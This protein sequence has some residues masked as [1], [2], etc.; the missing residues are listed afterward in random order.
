MRWLWRI[1]VVAALLVPCVYAAEEVVLPEGKSADYYRILLRK[2]RPGYLFDRFLNS[3]VES[4]DLQ[5][6]ETFLEASDD[7][8]AGAL[9]AFYYEAVGEPARASALYE[10]LIDAQP[11]WLELLYYK[12]SVDSASGAYELAAEELELLL[13]GKPDADLERDALK[14][15]GR[16]LL[17]SGREQE[18]LAAW[19]RLLTASGMEPDV[20]E[21]LLDMQLAEGLYDEALAN[22]DRLLK[23]TKDPYREVMLRLRR[24]SIL[25]RVDRRDD[26]IAGLREA[27]ALTGE[28]SW[29]RRDVMSR[30]EL[31]Y[32]GEDNLPGL[33]ECLDEMLEE[34]PGNPTLLKASAE[35]ARVR[36]RED[37]A[38]ESARALVRL[39]P[40]ARETKDWYVEMLLDMARYEEA[41]ATLEGFV[42][43]Y[44]EDNTLRARLAN[45]SHQAGD[46]EQ[47]LAWSLAYLQASAKAESDYMD[48]ARS[49][50]RFGLNDEATSVY[51]D[52]LAQWPDSPEGREAV[53]THLSRESYLHLEL[54]W[55]HYEWLAK[56]CDAETLTRLSAILLAANNPRRACQLLDLRAD[57]FSGDYR[58]LT[59]LFEATSA[60]QEPEGLLEIGQARIAAAESI[61]ELELATAALVYE[62]KKNGQLAE[63][64]E[65]LSAN[66]ERSENEFWLLVALRVA[67]NDSA[68]ADQLIL[69]ALENDPGNEMLL[70]C[71]LTLAKQSR[72]WEKAEQVL[73]QLIEGNPTQ[74]ALW[75]REL[76]PVLTRDGRTDEALEWI[77]DWKKVSPNA[78]RPYE[79]ERDA[80]LAANRYNEAIDAMRTATR[81]FDE[82]IDLKLALGR[83]YETRGRTADAEQLYW[84]LLN[85]EE[86]LEG[87]M[88]RLTDLIRLNQQTGLNKLIMELEIRSENA[89]ASPFPLLALAECYRVNHRVNERAEI[90]D[91]VLELRPND[92][93]VLRAK[94]ALE[95]DLGDYVAARKLMLRIA[96]LD[97]NGGAYAK[98][99]EF[100][101]LYGEPAVAQTMVEDPRISENVEEMVS[102]AA[103]LISAG[104]FELIEKPLAELAEKNPED[105]RLAFLVGCLLQEQGRPVVA[106]QAFA[107]LLKVEQE[108]PGAGAGASWSAFNAPNPMLGNPSMEAQKQRVMAQWK[109]QFGAWV[110]D[111][112][113]EMYSLAM[114]GMGSGR[115]R[116]NGYNTPTVSVDV[117]DSLEELE[118]ATL[119][120]LGELAPDV[121]EE[122]R[123]ALTAALDEHQPYLGL[124]AIRSARGVHSAEWWD[125]AETCYPEDEQIRLLRT[126]VASHTIESEEEIRTTIAQ[127]AGD[128]PELSF[129]LLMRFQHR[130][131]DLLP[132]VV[133]SVGHID[134]TEENLEV[135]TRVSAMALAGIA[136]TNSAYPAVVDLFEKVEAEYLAS[137][138]LNPEIRLQ[139]AA[140]RAKMENDYSGIL[141]L[142]EEVFNT[143]Q[144]L[145][146]QAA[147]YYPGMS[148]QQALQQIRRHQLQFTF[149]PNWLPNSSVMATYMMQQFPEES[150]EIL[151]T[152]RARPTDSLFRWLA[153][154]RMEKDAGILNAAAEAV[155]AKEPKTED[156]LFALACWYSVS[157][158][159]EQAMD[160]VLQLRA[161][162]T[163]DAD[164]REAWDAVILTL[165]ARLDSIPAD[166]RERYAEIQ[167]NL[168]KSKL[169]NDRNER[170]KLIGFL[171]LLGVPL[172]E[173]AKNM[174][175]SS[176]ASSAA[177]RHSS[178][179][180][181]QRRAPDF[182]QQIRTAIDQQQ[183]VDTA[184][185]RVAIMARSEALRAIHPQRSGY[186]Q[187]QHVLKNCLQ[188]I[189][190]HGLEERFLEMF[191]SADHEPTPREMFEYAFTLDLVGRSE[192]ALELYAQVAEARPDWEGVRTRYCVGLAETDPARALEIM[193]G[194][195]GSQR[196]AFIN[197]FQ[198]R[199]YDN[200][201]SFEDRLAMTELVFGMIAADETLDEQMLQQYINIL[202]NS[203]RNNWYF[204]Q[205]GQNSIALPAL[206]HASE[207]GSLGESW[208]LSPGQLPNNMN[209]GKDAARTAVQQRRRELNLEILKL[210]AE[211]L[212]GMGGNHYSQWTAYVDFTDA[213][214]DEDAAFL[215]ARRL[216]GAAPSNQ[217]YSY[218]NSGVPGE[219]REPLEVYVDEL[220]RRGDWSDADVLLEEMNDGISKTTLSALMEI[221]QEDDAV[222]Y[223]EHLKELLNGT[224]RGRNQGSV[225]KLLLRYHVE[226]GRSDDLEPLVWEAISKR[227]EQNDWS[228]AGGLAAAWVTSGEN[229]DAGA[230]FSRFIDELFTPAEQE[231]LASAAI[232]SID[233]QNQQTIY[234]KYQHISGVFQSLTLPTE[235]LSAFFKAVDPIERKMRHG[236]I[237]NNMINQMANQGTNVEW[238]QHMGFLGTWEEFPFFAFSRGNQS[239]MSRLCDQLNGDAG[240]PL[241]EAIDQ[242][243]EPTFG[244]E[245]MKAVV[246]NNSWSKRL[247]NMLA[248]L[249]DDLETVAENPEL[250]DWM[251]EWFF[252]MEA[253][254]NTPINASTLSAD[255]G[256]VLEAYAA[257]RQVFILEAADELLAF[258]LS[259]YLRNTNH[260]LQQLRQIMGPLV[261][262]DPKR[263]RALIDRSRRMLRLSYAVQGNTG[264]NDRQLL[265]QVFQRP[266]Y[267]AEEAL[268]VI[269]AVEEMASVPAYEWLTESYVRQMGHQLERRYRDE[270]MD[271]RE[272][273]MAAA[274]EALAVLLPLGDEISPESSLELAMRVDRQDRSALGE[275]V[276]EQAFPVSN[277]SRLINIYLDPE[278]AD[279]EW[280]AAYF[281]D[282]DQP[283]RNRVRIYSILNG[284]GNNKPEVL[285]APELLFGLVDALE[286][287]GSIRLP[288]DSYRLLIDRVAALEDEN[289]KT[290]WIGRLLSLWRAERVDGAPSNRDTIYRLVELTSA[291]GLDDDARLLLG[292]QAIGRYP[293]TYAIALRHGYYDFVE[294]ALPGKLSNANSQF[295]MNN[296]WIPESAVSWREQ[297]AAGVEDGRQ[298]TFLSVYLAAFPVR[299]DEGTTLDS[300]HWKKCYGEAVAAVE[301]REMARWLLRMRNHGNVK[302]DA[303]ELFLKYVEI[304]DFQTVL[305]GG[306]IDIDAYI[307]Y[308]DLLAE[309]EDWERLESMLDEL[310]ASA[311]R[312]HYNGSRRQNGARHLI[313]CC[314]NAGDE[315]LEKKAWDTA[316]TLEQLRDSNA[317]MAKTRRSMGYLSFDASD[318]EWE[319]LDPAARMAAY[320]KFD[321]DISGQLMQKELTKRW[322]KYIAEGF[323]QPEAR[324]RARID[325]F[326]EITEKA[327]PTEFLP[328]HQTF[329]QWFSIHFS[330]PDETA[331]LLQYLHGI[332][333]D[334]LMLAQ[335]K[336]SI[337]LNYLE[338]YSQLVPDRRTADIEAYLARAD[339]DDVEKIRF[340]QYG[341]AEGSVEPVLNQM[342][343]HL[344]ALLALTNNPELINEQLENYLLVFPVPVSEEEFACYEILLKSLQQNDDTAAAAKSIRILCAMG[345][346]DE[347]EA[348]MDQHS[349]KELNSEIFAA[350]LESGAVDWCEQQLATL[351]A[352]P[353]AER[354]AAYAK[355]DENMATQWAKRKKHDTWYYKYLTYDLDYAAER[356]LAVN[357]DLWFNPAFKGFVPVHRV[358]QNYRWTPELEQFFDEKDQNNRMVAHAMA[359]ISARRPFQDTCRSREQRT[360]DIER[361]LTRD[362]LDDIEILDFAVALKSVSIAEVM[363]PAS[364]R[365]V[366][367]ALGRNPELMESMEEAI[368]RIA[369]A[370]AGSADATIYNPCV[371]RLMSTY[372][373]MTPRERSQSV[374]K[375]SELMPT[376]AALERTDDFD[377][378]LNDDVLNAGTHAGMFRHALNQGKL[379]WCLQWLEP[380]LT[381]QVRSEWMADHGFAVDEDQLNALLA[382]VEDPD[383]RLA[384]GI[385]FEWLKAEEGRAVDF[386]PFATQFNEQTFT[387]VLW[388][389][390]SRDWLEKAGVINDTGPDPLLEKWAAGII[391]K[392]KGGWQGFS[393]PE[394]VAFEVY[395][396]SLLNAG[397]LDEIMDFYEAL[398]EMGLSSERATWLLDI[399]SRDDKEMVEAMLSG[400]HVV[401]PSRYA[402]LTPVEHYKFQ[403]LLEEVSKEI[404]VTRVRETISHVAP[405]VFGVSGNADDFKGKWN[406]ATARFDLLFG[407]FLLYS[408]EVGAEP[409]EARLQELIG[410]FCDAVL[411]YKDQAPGGYFGRY[412]WNEAAAFIPGTYPYSLDTGKWKPIVSEMIPS[413]MTKFSEP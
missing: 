243:E 238:M 288:S 341:L 398:P 319:K 13:A 333:D 253:Y 101:A 130:Y 248:T 92:V 76:V 332:E 323:S 312:E 140:A 170:I 298:K 114:Y 279:S 363:S 167:N 36:G 127:L 271:S 109:M 38:I 21:E 388:M 94:A 218:S 191:V 231:I 229:V 241:Q 394:E 121:P 88:T 381:E 80:L 159:V 278:N 386:E 235:S 148:T 124:L 158:K 340:I 281:M 175:F 83:L 65:K 233:H 61:E 146:E 411:I 222:L 403:S 348:I 35:L 181:S 373:A 361:Y 58:Y 215:I 23:A 28:G 90:L 232:A 322:D 383:L 313:K 325:L 350:A 393:K 66:T 306:D 404:P 79:L 264:Y 16:S 86:T 45:V 296:V 305:L 249:N 207:K 95:E 161:S 118:T 183:D 53:A 9:L 280:L 389:A 289:Q 354:A 334:S 82:S 225:L 257:W 2:P 29:L 4:N 120:K 256:E 198:Q 390:C 301:D 189:Q 99:V 176:Y 33:R 396:L 12:A 11:D 186:N 187:N 147:M 343:N 372:A 346:G 299:T 282:A 330:T 56:D 413:G 274:Q 197:A 102:L 366:V 342:K 73:T 106:A 32:F 365:A 6:L 100:E 3:W 260:A 375:L 43:R 327:S 356:E 193:N 77:E 358:L 226:D 46:D 324:L 320:K 195:S 244:S 202:S 206:N 371:D 374:L 210:G 177:S 60:M 173:I 287:D 329:R 126:L 376:L 188:Y 270:G 204:N 391:S 185:T 400:K 315:A 344:P 105:Y 224:G 171:E 91:R 362:D 254:R 250:F 385:Y 269:S 242:L 122:E 37:E 71:R 68:G 59:A 252:F 137:E 93:S 368:L 164:E 169:W 19:E 286:A 339:L 51:L 380:W 259:D 392:M 205:A 30:I 64:I 18:G 364:R 133:D 160:C 360:R 97:P 84:R 196:Q 180:R 290:E 119:M 55:K 87:R 349:E 123:A 63:W 397:R 62:I 317:S 81:Y 353:A 182:Y 47:A 166:Q 284:L 211:R 316:L 245:L 31:L 405:A 240:K 153:L 337:S 406:V 410:E 228:G 277:A 125:E 237:L 132:L 7:E 184:L 128:Y 129:N 213:P 115:M 40:N 149:P 387:N 407:C 138:G 1:W 145:S 272:A 117:P 113:L 399:P 303:D 110:S 70:R 78:T 293:Q 152:L 236:Y 41:I 217:Y 111:E 74:R 246:E 136:S 367:A 8:M 98:L 165:A 267:S 42:E 112:L 54:A 162:D 156:D 263:A 172:D 326:N 143:P 216:L 116:Y 351:R 336:A 227:V 247:P 108:R 50:A 190:Q 178:I 283:A 291:N 352:L 69:N 24:A 292:N 157:N 203:A 300:E 89:P 314:L 139:L 34:W 308:F 230:V 85:A 401:P 355:F 412:N 10:E 223:E 75:I 297:F 295:S 49:L 150:E 273:K 262:A 67:A 25:I 141:D 221:C 219:A 72:D 370:L 103:R 17:R 255:A 309:Q 357:F 96:D 57:D 39:M 200:N 107:A 265:Q 331:A 220:R 163:T 347:A 209:Y 311:T 318:M 44:P 131:P 174:S 307:A 142:A 408:G 14:L 285:N 384:A 52:M 104:C 266:S 304:V 379:D 251:Y 369:P 377:Q 144:D 208:E 359:L 179:R 276:V 22:C 258:R 402:R 382:Q 321:G 345:R 194:L 302:L 168:K 310:A 151:E 328:L 338:R 378:L 199:M 294:Q 154:S 192:E 261:E 201:T 155:A 335:L 212:S 5:S 395:V 275:W 239:L 15:L 48:V 234:M 214:L 135:L 20:A 409:D 26:A 27:F 134:I 268:L